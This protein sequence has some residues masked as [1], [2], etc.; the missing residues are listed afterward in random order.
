[1][2]ADFYIRSIYDPATEELYPLLMEYAE[3]RDRIH[4]DLV[5]EALNAGMSK[6][7]A[8]LAAREHPN[9]KDAQSRVSEILDRWQSIENGHFRDSYNDT[10]LFSMFGLG[11]YRLFSGEGQATLGEVLVEVA[12]GLTGRKESWDVFVALLDENH[13]LQPDKAKQLLR[14]LKQAED[15]FYAR[16][17][18]LGTYWKCMSGQEITPAEAGNWAEFFETKYRDFQ[19]FLNMAIDLDEPID[20]S[21]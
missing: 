12:K 7:E 19:R 10:N 3:M 21:Y 2:G 9:Y 15:V 16:L 18:S 20:V 8:R 14:L 13:R 1:M 17:D 6:T 4:D 5:A 11:N